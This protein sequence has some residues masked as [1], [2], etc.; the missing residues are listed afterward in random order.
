LF[1]QQNTVSLHILRRIHF[2]ARRTG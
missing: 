2:S 1:L